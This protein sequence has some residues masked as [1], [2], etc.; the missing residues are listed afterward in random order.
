MMKVCVKDQGMGI[1]VADQPFIF[2]R[3]FRVESDAMKDKKGFGIGLYI[4]K[5]IIERHQGKIGVESIEGQGSV[6]WFSLPVSL[7]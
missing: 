3:F 2:D 1:P 4:C 7:M 5:E 6:F